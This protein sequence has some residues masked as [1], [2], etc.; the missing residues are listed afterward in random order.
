MALE[1]LGWGRAQKDLVAASFG[2]SLLIG[3]V[4]LFN[5]F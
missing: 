5:V 2:I 1:F 4:F 3:L